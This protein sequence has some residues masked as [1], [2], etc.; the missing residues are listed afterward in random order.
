MKN[1][2]IFSLI[3]IPV[4]LGLF[5]GTTSAHADS[6]MMMSSSDLSLGA[7]GASV[8]TLQTFLVSKGYLTMPAGQ[9]MGYYGT[10]TQAAVMKY[11]AAAGLAIDGIDGAS[12]QMHITADGSSMMSSGTSTTMTTPS[13]TTAAANLRVTLNNLLQE[14]VSSSLNVLRAISDN[15]Q[16]ALTGALAEQDANAVALSAAIGS[17]YGSAAQ[18]AFL[19]LFRN[20]ITDSNN[21]TIAVKAGNMT[22]QTAALAALDQQLVGISNFLS[23]ANPYIDNAT[24]LAALRQHEMLVNQASVDYAKGDF[25]D[26][27]STET[28]ALAQIA[29]G[30]DYLANAIVQQYP[31][32]FE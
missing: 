10:L 7:T 21:Y 31:S 18:S 14:H 27:Y 13:T 26:S 19:T 29:G 3:A 30:G 4:A 28:Q 1:K 5:F 8:T 24:L 20:H 22:N 9:A 17:V 16:P 11:Q 23:G 2:A 32:K 12:T 25:A 15:N 6:T